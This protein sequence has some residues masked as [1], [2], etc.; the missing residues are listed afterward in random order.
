MLTIG[1]PGQRYM[2]IPCTIF[3]FATFCMFEII[4][5]LIANK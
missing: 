4:S 3:S 1:K 2:G 5:N